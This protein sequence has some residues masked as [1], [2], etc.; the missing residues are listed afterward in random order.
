MMLACQSEEGLA[1]TQDERTR[2]LKTSHM[3]ILHTSNAPEKLI[4]RAG[5]HKE[6]NAGW[7]RQ[8]E[9]ATGFGTVSMKEEYIIPPDE[10]RRLNVGECFVIAQGYGYKVHVAP[11][12]SDPARLAD[13]QAY[14]EQEA[15]ANDDA[16]ATTP[17]DA[18]KPTQSGT[19]Q[20]ND[21]PQSG[22][23]QPDLL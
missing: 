12:Q 11:I 23:T 7:S 17:T 18:E 8:G 2:I 10:A 19:T 6:V 21:Q 1:K 22:T 20:E 13:A 14:I 3:L 9:E 16:Q 5:K 15:R 4:E